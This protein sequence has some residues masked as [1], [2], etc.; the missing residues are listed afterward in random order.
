[1]KLS[2]L[3]QTVRRDAGMLWLLVAKLFKAAVSVGINLSEQ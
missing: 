1:M 3:G 2:N